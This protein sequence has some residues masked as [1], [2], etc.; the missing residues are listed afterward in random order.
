MN[1]NNELLDYDDYA[2]W[3]MSVNDW[4]EF[5]ELTESESEE[6]ALQFS[7]SKI[8]LSNSKVL[9]VGFGSGKIL[10]W[11]QDNGCLVEG[12]EIQENLLQLAKEK[13]FK[14][15]QN[16]IDTEGPYDLIVGFDVLEHMSLEQLKEL[17]GQASKKLN[18]SGRM[19]FRFPNADSYA[20]MAAQN[21]DY[22]H[23]TLIGQSKLCQIIEAFGLEIESFEGRVDYPVRK[24]KNMLLK[25]VR[26][27]LV[28][29]IGFD[30]PYFFSGNVVAVIKHAKVREFYKDI[31]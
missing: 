7:K 16:I 30:N 12:I 19:I 28:K 5:F 17:F 4:G 2:R 6:I 27:P 23:I 3:K 1:E 29:I 14:V 22:T 20:G 31:K 11:L 18:P 8:L 15:Y 13:K 9:E 26:W 24:I 25:L 21:G 10:R